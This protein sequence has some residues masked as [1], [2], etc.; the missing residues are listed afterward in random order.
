MHVLGGQFKEGD[1]IYA[2]LRDGSIQF[3]RGQ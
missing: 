2:D 1:Q 3:F